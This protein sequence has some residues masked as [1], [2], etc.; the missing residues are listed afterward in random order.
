MLQ[1]LFVKV[2]TLKVTFL[3]VKGFLKNLGFS[4]C[5]HYIFLRLGGDKNP[6]FGFIYA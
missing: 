5:H 1:N 2:K 4:P 6:M 3:Y